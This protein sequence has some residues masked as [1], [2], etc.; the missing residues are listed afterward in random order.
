[1]KKTILL[2]PLMLGACAQVYSEPL[3]QDRSGVQVYQAF[4]NGTRHSIGDCYKQA[5]ADCMGEF[6]IIQKEK[7]K[8][9]SI[10][11][12]QS[13]ESTALNVFSALASSRSGAG[14]TQSIIKRSIIYKCKP[15]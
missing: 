9:G 6:D 7:D 1:M 5:A 4:C 8:T 15:L 13:G 3:Y 11:G 10:K 12:F 14:A 2:L